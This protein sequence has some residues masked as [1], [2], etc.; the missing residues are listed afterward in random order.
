MVP[1]PA[2]RMKT[3]DVAS[4]A[5][6]LQ[7]ESAMAEHKKHV[8]FLQRSFFSN[9]WSLASVITVMEDTAEECR[10]WMNTENPSIRQVFEKF[11]CLMDTRIVSSY[12][13]FSY[14]VL[15]CGLLPFII[16]RCL[17]SFVV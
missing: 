6:K 4:P 15:Y 17:L 9:K 16:P 11:P 3:M 12:A 5:L 13:Q 10:R 7:S 8:D 1:P 14:V 2:K